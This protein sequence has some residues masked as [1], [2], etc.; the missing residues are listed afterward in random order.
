MYVLPQ[1]TG[2]LHDILIFKRQGIRKLNILAGISILG[3]LV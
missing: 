1:S 2:K 3:A